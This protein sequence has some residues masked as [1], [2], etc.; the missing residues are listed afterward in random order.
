MKNVWEISYAVSKTIR[1]WIPDV[2]KESQENAERN[3]YK[4]LGRSYLWNPWMYLRRNLASNLWWN[5][6][7][8]PR[9]ILRRYF[10]S[11]PRRNSQRSAGRNP[12]RNQEKFLKES[13]EESL[14]GSLYESWKEIS[15]IYPVKINNEIS[16]KKNKSGRNPRKNP[17]GILDR[18]SV[19]EFWRNPGSNPQKNSGINQW[20]NPGETNEEILEVIMRNCWEE[21]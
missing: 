20:I 21:S 1:E 18:I 3:S 16:K 11:I 8:N 17:G 4:N 5:P 15:K 2:K 7:R 12:F 19:K 10:K 13:L 6:C 9:R 14:I